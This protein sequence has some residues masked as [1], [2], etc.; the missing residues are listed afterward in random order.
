ML[1]YKIPKKKIPSS[2]QPILPLTPK[3]KDPSDKDDKSKF[4][5]IDLKARVGQPAGG[6]T[7]KKYVRRFEEGDPQE[8]IDLLLDVQAVW[9]LVSTEARIELQLCVRL[10]EGTR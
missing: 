9:R 7:Y 4:I 1:A 5:A 2:L 10:Y 3:T 6:A 8:W